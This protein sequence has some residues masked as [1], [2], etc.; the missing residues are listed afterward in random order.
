MSVNRFKKRSEARERMMQ[1]MYQMNLLKDF[2]PGRGR[3]ITEEY[4]LK[5]EEAYLCALEEV[6][7][8]N[9][10]EVNGLIDRYSVRWKTSRMAPTDLAILQIA[11]CEIKYMDDIPEKVS[12]DEAVELAKAYGTD[13]ASKFINGILGRVVREQS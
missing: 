13:K 3:R 8:Q 6:F 2:S 1:A 7:L 10:D 5:G 11:I 9:R 12:I 4:G